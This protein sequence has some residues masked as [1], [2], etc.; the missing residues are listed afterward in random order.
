MTGEDN[1]AAGARPDRYVSFAGIDCAGDSR[2]LIEAV[3]GHIDNP[4]RT[5]ALWEAFKTK[6][7]AAADPT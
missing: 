4:A 2:R 6:L 5:N 7:A 3:L 1:G